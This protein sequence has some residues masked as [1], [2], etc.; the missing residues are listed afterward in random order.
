MAAEIPFVLV[1]DAKARQHLLLIAVVFL[2]VGFWTAA[3]VVWAQRW[4][5]AVFVIVSVLGF[6]QAPFENGV[7]RLAIN[8]VTLA[9]LLSPGML[10]HVGFQPQFPRRKG[11]LQGPELGHVQR[12]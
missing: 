12:N 5:W 2:L 11:P 8:L 4:A 3:V 6:V 9:L 7:V 10:R 1:T